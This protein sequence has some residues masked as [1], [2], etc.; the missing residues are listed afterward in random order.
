MGHFAKIA[1]QL[2]AQ[3]ETEYPESQFSVRLSRNNG[4]VG[5]VIRVRWTGNP[6]GIWQ[7]LGL[8]ETNHFGITIEGQ[9]A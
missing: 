7:E 2:K 8:F 4:W 9:P 5:Q 6:E 3:L 1:K